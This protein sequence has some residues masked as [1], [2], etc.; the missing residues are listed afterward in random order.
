MLSRTL[1]LAYA[2]LAALIVLVWWR[3][4]DG[5]PIFDDHFLVTNARCFKTPQGLWNIL[6]FQPTGICR[7]RPLRYASYGLDVLIGGDRM[8]VYHVGNIVRHVLVAGLVGWM[9]TVLW[10]MFSTGSSS[11][12]S[13]NRLENQEATAT[14]PEGAAQPVATLAAVPAPGATSSAA[15]WAG[16]ICAALWALHPMQTDAVSYV[17]GR[18]DVLA[19]GLS[20]AATTFG[21]LAL[22]RGG[23]RWAATAALT[24]LAFSAKESSAVIPAWIGVAAYLRE[25]SLRAV[26][27]RPVLRGAL[28]VGVAAVLAFIAY[29]GIYASH[30][31]RE[32]F[33]WWGGSVHSNF[34]T[35]AWLHLRYVL[36]MALMTPMI[37]DYHPQTI[38]L[39]A[40]WSD[41]RTL[42]GLAWTAGLV[43]IGWAARRQVPL[44]SWGLAAWV[45]GLMPVSHLLPHHELYAEHYVYLPS[46]GLVVAVVAGAQWAWLRWGAA[47]AMSA[48]PRVASVA[49]VGLCFVLAGLTWV[50]NAVWIDEKTF[51]TS[52][53]A[54]APQNQRAIG[55]LLHIQA[56]ANDWEGVH[57]VSLRQ[58][59]D[60]GVPMWEP[61]SGDQAQAVGRCVAAA[62]RANDVERVYDWALVLATGHPGM[63]RGHRRLAEAALALGRV[64][65]A[66]DASMAWYVTT[67]DQDAL[68]LGVT[69]L[70]RGAEVEPALL[71]HWINAQGPGPLGL[72]LEDRGRLV[73]WLA[74]RGR[75]AEAWQIARVAAE[76]ANQRGETLPTGYQDL[77][78]EV[79]A[80]VSAPDRQAYGCMR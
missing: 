55:N 20:V 64:Q 32:P 7:Y 52:V 38:P 23:W 68:A 35:V 50:R 49:V 53:L 72:R 17:S 76:E 9:T 45:L 11:Q 39:A 8:A 24:A 6:T 30:S 18:R 5:G 14:V 46:V 59:C 79:A 67:R 15:L 4:I 42:L 73:A 48:I 60:V 16:V 63:G 61:G 25:G 43:A 62:A 40:G 47:Y 21:L 2:S 1:W 69:A 56:D 10:R 54:A 74:Q 77:L 80:A 58:L 34:A 27:A 31:H 44:V 36:Q 75:L 71:A 12:F 19:G 26:F 22:Q 70:T 41:P 33:A 57:G 78:C 13:K 65:M 66:W 37:G 29:R 3:T 28:L 51:Y